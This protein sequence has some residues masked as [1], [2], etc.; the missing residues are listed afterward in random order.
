[1]TQWLE[2]VVLGMGHWGFGLLTFLESI[3]PP[4]PSEI[5]MPLGGYLS[6]QR[7]DLSFFGV[8]VA[9]IIGSVIGQIPWYYAG[10]FFHEERLKA[11][12]DRYGKWVLISS[13]EIDTALEWFDRHGSIA[14][15]ICR[16]IPGLRTLISIPAGACRMKLWWFLFLT[17]SGTT[18]WITALAYAGRVFGDHYEDVSQ[19]I[20]W[21]ALAVVAAILA[22]IVVWYLRKRWHE[23]E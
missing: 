15:F 6:A 12:A 13:S 23:Q 22:A 11:W 5:V 16:M 17:A 9:G 20:R 1:M 21:T 2:D 14:V 4:I 7:D 10:R 8:V 18:I 19:V 3:F